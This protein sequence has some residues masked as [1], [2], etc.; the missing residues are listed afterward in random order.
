MESNIDKIISSVIPEHITDLIN[1]QYYSKIPKAVD[2]EHILHSESFI[3]NPDNDIA[4]FSDHGLN[5][6]KNV[7]GQVPDILKSVHG[8]H[9]P[10]AMKSA[11]SS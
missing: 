9:I 6:V 2:F 5:H 1:K 11:F 3:K 7:A 10:N 8:I 4:L